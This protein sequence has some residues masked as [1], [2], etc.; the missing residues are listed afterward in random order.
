MEITTK[1]NLGDKVWFMDKNKVKSDNIRSFRIEVSK[2]PLS[3]NNFIYYVDDIY[4]NYGRY[5]EHELFAS[6]Q[7][8]LESL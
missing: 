7:Q 1:Y 4:G 3:S 2:E 8:L 6:K 5:N